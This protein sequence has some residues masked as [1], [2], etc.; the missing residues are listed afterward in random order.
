[1]DKLYNAIVTGDLLTLHVM[2]FSNRDYSIDHCQSII[3]AC[4][5]AHPDIAEE[6]PN[7]L[8]LKLPEEMIS[9]RLYLHVKMAMLRS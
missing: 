3:D 4:A 8:I 9:I 2:I 1:M 7:L 5:N 6:V